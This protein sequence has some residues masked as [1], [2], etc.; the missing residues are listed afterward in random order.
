MTIL[1]TSYLES[2]VASRDNQSVKVITNGGQRLWTDEDGI[3][4]VGLLPFLLDST[5]RF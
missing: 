3:S 5:A 1:R 4:H 2:L